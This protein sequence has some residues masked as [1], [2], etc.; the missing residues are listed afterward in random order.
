MPNLANAKKALRQAKKRAV[1]NTEIKSDIKT[2]FKKAR[3]LIDAKAEA[4]KIKEMLTK[5]QKLV[6]KAVQKK[7][8]KSNTGDRKKSRLMAYFNQ[9]GKKI[10]VKST[11]K[12]APQPVAAETQDEIKDE[13]PTEE[14][15]E[16]TSNEQ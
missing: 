2:L 11:E 10:V 6:D 9:G 15:A 14:S 12:A 7:V 16:T 1:R 13:E 8:I 3:K 5:I 4:G